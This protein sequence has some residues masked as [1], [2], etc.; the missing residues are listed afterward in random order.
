LKQLGAYLEKLAAAD[1]FSGV[2]LVARD[3]KSTF[4]KAYGLASRAYNVPNKIDTK[5]NV[6]SINK[7]FT[8]VVVAQLAENGRLS[9]DDPVGKHLPD[10]PNKDVAEKVTLHHLLTHTS[11]L[12]DC[13]DNLRYLPV[14]EKTRRVRDYFPLFEKDPLTFEPGARYEYSNVGYILLGAVIEKVSG[15]DYFAYMSERVFE[16]AG[17]ADT[18]FYELDQD[19]P[20]I[21]TGYE[22]KLVGNQLTMLNNT[23]RLPMKGCPAG[24]GYSTAPDLLRFDQALRAHKLLSRK[25]TETLLAGKVKLGPEAAA[26]YA[27]GFFDEP[28]HGRRIVHHGGGFAGIDTQLD[29]YLDQGY[30]VVVLTNRPWVTGQ[31][32]KDRIREL[33]TRE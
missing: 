15:Q 10:Y 32:V 13:L 21:A 28:V 33:L 29:M 22:P 4:Q 18:G 17:M 8:G 11:G 6:A 31:R 7:M 1:L 27:Y 12:G 24:L 14:R 2:V 5:F 25:S 16:P 26:K 30:T 20:G 23:H 9:F 3:A 19:T